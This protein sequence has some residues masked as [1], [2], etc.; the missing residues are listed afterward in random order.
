MTP[1]KKQQRH[2]AVRPAVFDENE[3]PPEVV[4]VT[5][6]GSVTGLF[7]VVSKAEGYLHVVDLLGDGADV[8]RLPESLLSDYESDLIRMRRVGR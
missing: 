7:L 1:K 3:L 2:A 5:E 8:I 4:E 6:D